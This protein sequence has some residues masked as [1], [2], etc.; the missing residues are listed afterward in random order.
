MLQSVFM[1]ISEVHV[2]RRDAI[3]LSESWDSIQKLSGPR[4]QTVLRGVDAE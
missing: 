4:K 2:L 1:K 3:P